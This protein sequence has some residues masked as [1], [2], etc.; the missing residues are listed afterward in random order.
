MPHTFFLVPGYGAQGASGRD[1]RGFF[2][3][4]G[5]GCIVNSS[6]GIIAAWKRDARF[7]DDV[8]RAAA[9]AALAM[10]RDLME[11]LA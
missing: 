10:K 11:A 1:L 3:A 4:G 9:E 8:G 6:R 7:G 5:K 2:D